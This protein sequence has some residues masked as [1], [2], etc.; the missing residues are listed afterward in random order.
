MRAKKHGDQAHSPSHVL[1]R[2]TTHFSNRTAFVCRCCH[3]S[4]PMREASALRKTR[5]QFSLTSSFVCRHPFATFAVLRR[6]GIVRRVPTVNRRKYP[7]T[8]RMLWHGLSS[9]ARAF[10]L[11]SSSSSHCVASALKGRLP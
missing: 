9:V 2:N 5:N 8:S 11:V 7:L 6:R 10:A 4:W 3:T 1:L